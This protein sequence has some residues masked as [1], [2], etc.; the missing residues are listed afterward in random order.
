MSSWIR[1]FVT[2]RYKS[3]FLTH[4]RLR[5][6]R[7]SRVLTWNSSTHHTN[8]AR[9][10]P[11]MI[12]PPLLFRFVNGK[13]LRLER[14]SSCSTCDARR[15]S[16][17][18]ECPKSVEKPITTTC[19]VCAKESNEI[20]YSIALLSVWTDTCPASQAGLIRLRCIIADAMARRERDYSVSSGGSG[21]LSNPDAANDVTFG[22]LGDIKAGDNS[23]DIWEPDHWAQIQEREAEKLAFLRQQQAVS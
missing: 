7:D 10:P 16:L 8:K 18:V 12:A 2:R 15:D 9:T 23:S 5:A 17:G 21:S 13:E 20:N 3:W 11:L 6:R 1:F 22:N 19:H 14:N 4:R